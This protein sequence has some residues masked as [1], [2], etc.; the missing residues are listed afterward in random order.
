MGHVTRYQSHVGLREN[1][2]LDGELPSDGYELKPFSNCL[3]A[4]ILEF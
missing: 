1:L 4:G 3:L 2:K